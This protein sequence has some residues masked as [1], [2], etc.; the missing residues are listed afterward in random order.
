MS[1]MLTCDGASEADWRG[2]DWR[3]EKRA[4]KKNARRHEQKSNEGSDELEN[5]ASILRKAQILYILLGQS[6][7]EW[8]CHKLLPKVPLVEIN[9]YILVTHGQKFMLLILYNS[10]V[11]LEILNWHKKVSKFFLIG[12]QN[13]RDYFCVTLLTNSIFDT[14]LRL[15]FINWRIGSLFRLPRVPVGSLFLSSQVPLSFRNSELGQS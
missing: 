12:F 14:C 1:E 6:R 9:F 11:F 8:L 15:N 5:I 13:Y 7:C 3:G 10:G 2:E 4:A